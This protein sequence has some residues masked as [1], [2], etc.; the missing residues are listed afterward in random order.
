MT[1]NNLVLKKTID[2]EE[3]VLKT[4]RLYFRTT[5]K[6]A[7]SLNSDLKNHGLDSLDLIELAM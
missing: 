7:I 4:V 2:I 5:H 1:K 6:S 3:Y